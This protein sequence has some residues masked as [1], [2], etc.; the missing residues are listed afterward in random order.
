M[1]RTACTDPQCL[2]K[3]ALHFFAFTFQIKL[4]NRSVNSGG[5]AF[6]R[7]LPEDI[8]YKNKPLKWL[9]VNRS[10]FVRQFH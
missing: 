7:E 5:E 2:Y 8:S 6:P 10:Y 4:N 3:G 9:K 1:G